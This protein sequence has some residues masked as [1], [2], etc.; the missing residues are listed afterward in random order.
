MAYDPEAKNKRVPL[1]NWLKHMGKS[2]H[3]LKEENK[4]MLGEFEKEVEAALDDFET[5]DL[6]NL[7]RFLLEKV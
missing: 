7:F 3:L 6:D 4:E 5:R 1:G 2:R